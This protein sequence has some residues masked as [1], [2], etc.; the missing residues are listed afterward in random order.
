[1]DS[2]KM[3]DDIC[4]YIYNEDP[5]NLDIT[6]KVNEFIKLF[7]EEKDKMWQLL[8]CIY[9]ANLADEEDKLKIVI[10]HLSDEELLNVLKSNYYINDKGRPEGEESEPIVWVTEAFISRS[11]DSQMKLVDYLLECH[12]PRE[13]RHL[14]DTDQ[15]ITHALF[16]VLFK[17]SPEAVLRAVKQGVEMGFYSDFG[18]VGYEYL[19]AGNKKYEKELV[20][21]FLKGWSVDPEF[22]FFYGLISECILSKDALDFLDE[23]IDKMGIREEFQEYTG[24]A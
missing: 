19:K 8:Y 21:C 12:K 1:M 24:I 10:H 5:E 7:P 9:E 18:G 15:G 14:P 3:I 17:F 23:Q 16:D 6:S 20:A 4:D 22:S 11:A 13:D 2:Q